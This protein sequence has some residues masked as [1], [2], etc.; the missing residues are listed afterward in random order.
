M[1]FNYVINKDL[2]ILRAYNTRLF[3]FSP[4]KLGVQEKSKFIF[5]NIDQLSCKWRYLG[6]FFEI[7]FDNSANLTVDSKHE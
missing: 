4:Y 1:C 3:N 6:I 5:E 7:K 2:P